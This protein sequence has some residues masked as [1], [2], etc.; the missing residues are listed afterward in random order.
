MN[1]Y[2]YDVALSFAGEQRDYVKKVAEHLS[3][4]GITFFYDD[5]Q[6]NNLW[7]K[8]LIKYFE[9]V[10]Y[11]DSRYCVIFISKEY[12]EK[13]WTKLESKII[14]E[15]MFFQNDDTNFQQYILPVRFDDTKI[16]GIKDSLGV[17]Y[18]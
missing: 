14:E 9:K 5:Y 18:A 12:R 6:K 15:H 3:T 1:R 10:Y 17:V 16:P 8:N 11:Q 4:L 7:G 13:C 2:V